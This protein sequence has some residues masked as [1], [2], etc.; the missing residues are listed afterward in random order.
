MTISGGVGQGEEARVIIGF[1]YSC[2][3][4]WGWVFIYELSWRCP[5]D[6]EVHPLE[7]DPEKE[8][9]YPLG[10]VPIFR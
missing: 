7:S 10:H 3:A 8:T 6:L 5:R 1:V 9:E 4:G 2:I